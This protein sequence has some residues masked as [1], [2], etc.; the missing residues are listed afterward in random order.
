MQSNLTIRIAKPSDLAEVVELW[1]ELMDFHS[2]LDPFFTQSKDGP[3]NFLKWVEKQME[4][5][6]A[7]LIIA[8]VS[9]KIVGYAKIEISK[10]PPVFE[11]KQYGMIS[12]V[13]VAEEYRRQGIGEALFDKSEEWFEGKGISRIELRVA[14]VNP[15]ARGFWERMGFKPYMTTMYK[16]E[17]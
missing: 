14:N 15:V 7:E 12:D 1:K 2:D 3:N 8:D 4:L 5:E 13:S 11:K 10:Y 9:G 16:E 6:D 17:N